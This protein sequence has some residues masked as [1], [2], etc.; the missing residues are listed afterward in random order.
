VPRQADDVRSQ[1]DIVAKVFSGW[2]KK[3]LRAADAFYARRRA[4][5]PFHAKTIMV[6][7]KNYAGAKKSKEQL[8][9]IFAALNFELFQQYRH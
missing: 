5:N 4:G 1:G 8:L 6:A 2:R 9:R 7:S 3:V